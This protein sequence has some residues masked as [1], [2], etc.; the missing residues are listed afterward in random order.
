MSPKYEQ[1]ERPEQDG[2]AP[3]A[4]RQREERERDEAFEQEQDRKRFDR[5]HGHTIGGVGQDGDAERHPERAQES[6][7]GPLAPER[8]GSEEKHR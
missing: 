7:R 5:N 3:A 6:Q 1:R 2:M 8:P 4:R